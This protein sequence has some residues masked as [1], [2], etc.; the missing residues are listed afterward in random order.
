MC[1]APERQKSFFSEINPIQLEPCIN[2]RTRNNNLSGNIIMMFGKFLKRKSPKR[3]VIIS[4]FVALLVV[5]CGQEAKT[6]P[7]SLTEQTPIVAQTAKLNV[8][9]SGTFVSGEH[10]TQGRVEIVNQNGKRIIQLNEQ[11]NTSTSG[12]DLVVVLHRS[13]NVIAETTPPAYPLKEGN[14]IVLA[15]LKQYS[16]KQSYEVPENIN[17]NDFQSVVIWCRRFN[18]TF[19]AATLKS[20]A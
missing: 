13:A 2:D 6:Q 14:Y 10:P 8:L 20:A 16:G 1:N 5:G 12:P 7:S 11:F 15:P 18:A 19:G 9:S 3:F 4:S 17:L